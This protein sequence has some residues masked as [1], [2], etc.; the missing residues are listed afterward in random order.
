VYNGRN[1]IK[2]R[3]FSRIFGQNDKRKI[4]KTKKNVRAYNTKVLLSG[5]VGA[6]I[7][8]GGLETR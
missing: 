3:G 8:A 6:Q 2:S 1:A 5:R 7:L 4:G